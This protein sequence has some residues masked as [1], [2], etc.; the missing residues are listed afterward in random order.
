MDADGFRLLFEYNAWANDRVLEKA[1]EVPQAAYYASAEGLSFGTLHATLVHI[2]LGELVW[3]SRWRGKKPPEAL[4]DGR[5]AATLAQTEVPTLVRLREMWDAEREK[6]TPFFASLTDE[7][8]AAPLRYEDQHGNP[9]QQPLWQLMTHL[10]NH[11]TQFRAEA[12][13]RLTQLG[14]SPGDLDLI[15]WLRRVRRA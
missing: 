2:M 9:N 4:K 10:L 12:A 3:L 14:Y 8:V 11:G 15:V 7:A 13:V 6:Q 5:L 1:A